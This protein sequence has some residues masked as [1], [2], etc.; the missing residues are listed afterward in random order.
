MEEPTAPQPSPIPPWTG[1]PQCIDFFLASLTDCLEHHEACG[2]SQVSDWAPTRLLDVRPRVSGEDSIYL[3]ETGGA[4]LLRKFG[5]Y[6]TLSH[7]WGQHKPLC[8]TSSTYHQ[9]R[10][11]IPVANLPQSFV[12]AV[13]LCRRF[14]VRFL[15]IDSLW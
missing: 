8:L 13:H 2:R 1:S 6:I 3:T 15:W 7:Q 12:D 11:G 4:M 9:L 14:N 10:R 5:R